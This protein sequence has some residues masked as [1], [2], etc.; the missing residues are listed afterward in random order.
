MLQFKESL[1][2]PSGRLSSWTGESCCTWKGVTCDIK[3]GHVVKL[4]LRNPFPQTFDPT[5]ESFDGNGM[6]Y[7]LS[8]KVSPSL[9]NLQHLSYFDLSMNNFQGTQIPGFLG[10]LTRLK[11]LN[12]SGASFAGKIP[13]SIGNLSGLHYLDLNSYTDEPV[14][15]DIQWLSG[16]SSLRYLDLGGLDLS[17][18][19]SHW[20]PT[21]NMLASLSELHLSQCQLL[22]LPNSLPFINITS[23][24][25][26][27]LSRNN[28]N[29]TMPNWLFNLSSLTD[30]DLSSNYG[31]RGQLSRNLGNL[32]K[33]RAL[34]L[35]SNNIFGTLTEV[36]DGLSECTNSSMETLDLTFNQL[37]GN[38]PNS[39]G[40]LKNLRSLRLR[41]N[42]F[43]GSIPD[44]IGN[45]SSLEQLYLSFNQMSGA[46]PESL[47]KL[48]SLVYLDLHENS[49]EGVITEAHL[50]NMSRLTEISI[51]KLSENISVV[52]NISPDWIPP[53]KLKFVQIQ[54][55][56][57]GPKFPTWLKN[58]D[59]LKNLIIN[60]ARIS[61]SIPEWFLRL[62]LHLDE[63]D[64]A[65]NN[66]SGMPPNSLQFN[67]GSNVDLSS[68]SFKGPLPLWS[69]NLTTLY[70]RN[71][72]FSG[73]IPRDIGM[74]LPLLTDLDISRNSLTGGIPLSIGNMTSLTT[75]VI[76]NNRLS[77]DIP[78]FWS[79]IPDLYILDMSNNSLTGRIPTSIGSLSFV[80]FLILSGNNLSGKL[81][82]SLRNCTSTFSLDLGDNQLSG[83]LPAWIG[84]DMPSLL[85]LRLRNNSLTGNIPSSICALSSLHILDLSENRLSGIIP[86]CL[87]NLSGFK[88]GLK[89]EDTEPYEGRLQVVAKGRVLVYQSTL[90]LVNSIDLSSNKFR[91]NI[92]AELTSLFRLGTLNLSMNGLTGPIPETIGRLER[93]ETLDL[94][95]NKLTGRI[96]QSMAAL[97]FLNHLNLSSNNLSG[98][99]PTGNQFQTLTDPSIYE[100]NIALCGDPLPTKCENSGTKPYPG[101]NVDEDENEEDD[102][103]KLWFFLV[104]GLGYFLGFWGVCASLILKKSW[105]DA[106]FNFLL[107]LKDRIFYLAFAKWR[108]A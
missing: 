5:P 36:I 50:I 86:T 85:I 62:G 75:L 105:G 80:K 81:P 104:V 79:N 46:I 108:K 48:V 32:C 35:N 39:L 38:I 102:L 8:G 78:D 64:L 34:N 73:P 68:N 92:P 59:Q 61:D 13:S 99:I 54:S 52:F 15:N 16:L 6:V 76:S 33:L 55:C 96:P 77:G 23:L 19:S 83:R 106:Y 40:F 97:T 7:E 63:L 67:L 22:N 9:V 71:N 107:G 103:E 94:S 1:S 51:G 58:Q 91:G 4:N 12:L 53:F 98:R 87:G 18:A 93:I 84:K 95:M 30:L 41:N 42:S 82:S 26:L 10:S 57:L 65:Y 88:A 31:I 25:A 90:Y 69:S 89:T 28:F 24:S 2:D 72:S 45:L 100:G 20:L 70:L 43:T 27:D 66:L 74:V 44:T 17:R 49:W 21:I 11:Y 14:K 3:T 29:S 37:S 56:Q 60:F 101:G 47:G